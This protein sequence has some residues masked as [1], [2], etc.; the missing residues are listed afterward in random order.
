MTV[1][2][3]IP[4]AGGKAQNVQVTSNTGGWLAKHVALHAVDQLRA[5]PIPS[6]V[7]AELH[8]DRMQFEESFTIFYQPVKSQ[9]RKR[10]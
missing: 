1:T 9:G 2:F 10:L 8:S 6:Q 7:M 3:D 5:P 4:A